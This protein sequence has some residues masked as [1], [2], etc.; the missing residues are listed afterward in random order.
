VATTDPS[1]SAPRL[2]QVW[3]LPALVLGV[4]LFGVG[5]Y[6]ARPAKTDHGEQ[7]AKVLDEV[8][9]LITAGR[10]DTAVTGLDKLGEQVHEA[11][12]AMQ[13]QF[14][15]LVGDALFLGQRS[16]GWSRPV[17]HE[18]IIKAYEK[19]QADGHGLDEP[20][21][22]RLAQT[23]AAM[24]KLE[25]AMAMLGDL[26]ETGAAQRQ[27][28]LKGLITTAMQR[29]PVKA[30]E[31]TQLINRLLDEPK[32]S[33]ANEVWAVAR[34]AELSLAGGKSA[35]VIDMLLRR[36]SRLQDTPGA[37]VAELMVMLGRAYLSDGDS[38]HAERW[39]MQ[40][41]EKL[42][43]GDPLN[44]AA[45]VGMGRIRFA[46]DNPADAV[47]LFSD[48]AAR[49]NTT[50]W[51]PEALLGR[52]DASARLGE[53]DKAVNDYAE[54]TQ[55]VRTSVAAA[56]LRTRL[57]QSLSTQYDLRFGQ[58][59][60]D[61]ALRYVDLMR[62][63]GGSDRPSPI[64]L[65]KEAMVH[66]QIARQRLG[67][68]ENEDET[69]QTWQ[70]LDATTRAEAMKHMMAGAEA[71][72][73]H[74][75]TVAGEN[76]ELASQ[77]LWRAADYFDRVGDYKGAV[78]A[79]REFIDS[80]AEDARTL[81]ATQR[82]A[83][84]YQADGQYEQAIELYS[85]LI[86]QNPKSPEAYAS[87]VPL[88]RCHLARGDQY[89]AEAE[90]VLRS[91]V[92]NHPALRPESQEYRQALIELGQLYYR[93]GSDGD[94]EQA[95][96]RLAEV[97]ARYGSD[98]NPADHAQLQFQLADAYRKSVQQIDT[99]L[100]GSLPPSKRAEFSAERVR[101][102]EEAGE[103]FEAVI[104]TLEAVPQ[105]D[106][107]DLQKL[108][109]RN[110]YFFRA[111]CA[112][113]LGRYDGAGGAIAMYDKAIQRY[114]TDPASLVA[115]IQIVNS[116]GQM[117]QW[118]KAR[119]ANERAKIRLRAIPDEAFDDPNLP[120]SRQAWQRWLDWSTQLSGSDDDSSVSAQQP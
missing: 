82:L 76:P 115:M 2:G 90:R 15:L 101:R 103:S 44:A 66:E 97:I 53:L 98:Q 86:E 99:K 38:R 50:D 11:P 31:V 61:A 47:S 27:E 4:I 77:S 91:V 100:E 105:K 22:L 13:R 16:K 69:D 10:F 78:K 40:A 109:L 46:E 43:D 12:P 111:D 56:P 17:N 9:A 34:Q 24:G 74:A 49:F 8:Q 83:Q 85:R 116:Y 104:A 68:A 60:Y 73:A 93:R 118:A 92:T 42:D 89:M 117:K 64:V 84:A 7:W 71:Y 70:K 59:D 36:L 113:A 41:Q 45:L 107:S 32:L 35:S 18:A 26:G 94:Y 23:L 102:L 108:Y 55:L 3:Q 79:F 62:M 67:L 81:A 119:A 19:G 25:E 106:L 51:Y 63:L 33:L 58:G 29:D 30:A 14:Q 52:A 6:M 72:R 57:S 20:R 96:E 95:I 120:M 110:S 37:P 65:L 87:L 39:F 54:L 5:L 80:H 75:L 21:K 112:Y 88:A 48:A 1:Q 28:I 114:E